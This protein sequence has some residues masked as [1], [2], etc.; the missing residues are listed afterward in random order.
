MNRATKCII[1][2]SS[3]ENDDW[4]EARRKE[5]KQLNYI[6]KY[7]KSHNLICME[8]IRRGCMGPSEM[9]RILMGAIGKLKKGKAEVILVAN[10]L[11]ISRSIRD[12]YTQIG[13]VAEAGYRIISV[14][15]GELRFKLY[16]PETGEVIRNEY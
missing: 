16:D 14:D 3:K 5:N 12:A 6:N 9:N 11:S 10:I 15:E 1:I 2:L 8:I 4:D 13:K 7:A